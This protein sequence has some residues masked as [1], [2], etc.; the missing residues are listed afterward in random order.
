MI[1]LR[2]AF[3]V[4]FFAL[5][6]PGPAHAQKAGTSASQIVTPKVNVGAITIEAQQF[7]VPSP[8]SNRKAEGSRPHARH[9]RCWND[10]RARCAANDLKCP[11]S[12]TLVCE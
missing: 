9:E 7:F 6:G 11:Q 10:C 8:P 2:V 1:Y 5:T 12:C 3:I 4:A